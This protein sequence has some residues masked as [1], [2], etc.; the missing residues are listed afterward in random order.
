VLPTS[1]P[2]A[3]G[4]TTSKPELSDHS[5]R[6]SSF[7]PQTNGWIFWMYSDDAGALVEIDRLRQNYLAQKNLKIVPMS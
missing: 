1:I 7:H 2:A 6:A 4:C 3:L 5:C